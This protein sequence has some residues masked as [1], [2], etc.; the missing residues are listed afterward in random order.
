MRNKGRALAAGTAAVALIVI[1]L[2]YW[3]EPAGSLPSFFPGHEAGSVHHHVKHGLAAV[4]L[5]LGCLVYAWFASA[6]KSTP[7]AAS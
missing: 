7:A 6:S 1:G 4:V 2:V 5:A 3:I